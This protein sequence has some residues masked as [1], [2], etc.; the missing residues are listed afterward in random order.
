[1]SWE[2]ALGDCH[3]WL[4]TLEDGSVDAVITDPPYHT[5]QLAFDALEVR[6]AELWPLIY[7]KCKPSAVQVIFGVQPFVTDLINS[8][9]KRFRY[10]IIWEKSQATGF[11]D[12]PKRPLKAHENI[13]VFAELPNRTTYNPQKLAASKPPSLRRQLPGAGSGKQY[14][15]HGR[16]NPKAYFDDG[17]RHPVT[18]AYCPNGGSSQ[19]PTQ[20]PL[21][22]LAYLVKTYSNP[23]DLV[24][25][26]F[27]GS[28]TTAH[29]CILTGR[30]FMGCEIDEKYHRLATRRLET[31]AAQ[32]QLFE[33][34]YDR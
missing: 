11:L 29:A 14:S 27:A 15:P 19:H 26:P 22:L 18:V 10:E 33:V 17:S 13:L 20:K 32:S 12:A 7:R 5:T 24:V 2:L 9:R 21:E 16:D 3:E 1:M 23:G 34:K 4:E 6:W 30:R 25:D 31:V 8:N 28:G